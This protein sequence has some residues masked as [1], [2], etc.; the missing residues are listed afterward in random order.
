MCYYEK[1][2][3]KHTVFTINCHRKWKERETRANQVDV[4]M[5]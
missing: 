1:L 4:K 5:A 2:Q 3:L